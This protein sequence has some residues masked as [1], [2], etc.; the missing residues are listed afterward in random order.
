VTGL[1]TGGDQPDPATLCDVTV[2]DGAGATIVP[3]MVDSHAHLS[4]PGGA[5][6]IERGFDPLDDLLAVGEENGELVIRSG[7]RRARRCRGQVPA[8]AAVGAA[9][10]GCLPMR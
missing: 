9:A 5:R 4:M 2:I 10:T 7:V 8:A 3:G 6:W 1:W